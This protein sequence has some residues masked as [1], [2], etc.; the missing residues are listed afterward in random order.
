LENTVHDPDN[1]NIWNV[2]RKNTIAPSE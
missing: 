2:R 1:A